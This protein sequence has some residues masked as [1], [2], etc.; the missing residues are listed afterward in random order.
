MITVELTFLPSAKRRVLQSFL[1]LPE[2]LRPTHRSAG[3]N[4][5][6]TSIGDPD[7]SCD[8]MEKSGS[9]FFLK[10]SHAT[11][12]LIFAGDRPIVCNCFLDL[13]P[14]LVEILLIHM[15]GLHPIFGFACAWD[16]L[17][18]RNRVTIKQGVNT[19]ESWVGRNTQK[20]IPGLYWLTLLP[21]AL[22]K[23][24]GISLTTIEQAALEHTVLEDDQHLFRFYERPEDW[25][26]SQSVE[27]LSSA[28][29]GIFNVDKIKPA[30]MT[31]KNFSD[32]GAMLRKWE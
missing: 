18:R 6:G 1:T 14:S 23:K 8:D 12:D 2:E 9:G 15:A 26:S 3:E 17:E 5:I 7:R 19:I 29:P 24:H 4:D 25:R 20:Y 21:G 28:S 32:L 31:A 13:K 27:E 10:R 16:E 22:A 11:Y 30:L